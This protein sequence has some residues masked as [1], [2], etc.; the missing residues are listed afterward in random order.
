MGCCRYLKNGHADKKNSPLNDCASPLP[1]SEIYVN[2]FPSS[3][4]PL[5]ESRHRSQPPYGVATATA[6]VPIKD[7]LMEGNRG[8][9][10]NGLNMFSGTGGTLQDVGTTGWTGND[11]EP[12]GFQFD[13][14]MIGGGSAAVDGAYSNDGP[15]IHPSMTHHPTPHYQ[16]LPSGFLQSHHETSR[17]P[18]HGPSCGPSRERSMEPALPAAPQSITAAS[19]NMTDAQFAS[20]M[21]ILGIRSPPGFNNAQVK[22]RHHARWI[23]QLA[24]LI[25]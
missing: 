25:I 19:A 2:P 5:V 7:S 9:L 20:L 3:F 12:A 15:L 24:K 22:Y 13:L 16:Q 18:S 10:G 4:M 14:N 21:G 8:A 23:L 11:Q 6:T 17:G 1:P